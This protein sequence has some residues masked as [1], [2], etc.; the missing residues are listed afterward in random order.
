MESE[1]TEQP[2]VPQEEPAKEEQVKADTPKEEEQKKP[3]EGQQQKAKKVEY[4]FKE[5]P[6]TSVYTPEELETE[7]SKILDPVEP[8]DKI[9]PKFSYGKRHRIA[10]FYDDESDEFKDKEVKVC[11]WAR[12][13]KAAAKGAIYFVELYDGSCAGSLQVVVDQALSNFSELTTEGVGTSFQF[14]GTLIESPGKGQKYE[15][16][17]KEN[18][19][20]SMKIF[21]TCPQG[22]Y[23]LPKKKHT[24]EYLRD[25]MHLRP[26]TNLIGAV[27]RVRNSLAMATHEFFQKR[28][29]LYV[30][31]PII[32]ASDCEGAGEMFQVTTVL[33]DPSLPAKDIPTTQDGKVDYS[34]DFFKKPAFLTV[35]GQ[36]NVENFCCGMGDVYTFSP[37]FRAEVSHTKKHLAEFWMIEPEMAF[38]DL[39]DDMDCAEE[40]VKYC[41]SYVMKN[42]ADDLEYLEKFESRTLTKNLKHILDNDFGR[43]SYTEA[44]K[45]L[46]SKAKKAKFDVAPEWGVD[47]ATE[48]ERF[49]TEKI[50]KK[51]IF[52]YN[53]PKDIKAFYMRL[54]DDNKTVAAMDCLVPVIGELVG[55][56]QREERLDVLESRISECNLPSENYWWYTELRK[57]GSIPHSGFG[58]GFERLILLCTGV[59]NIRDIIPFPRWPG[60]ADF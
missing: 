41:I 30:H 2:Q 8:S 55:G 9:K 7:N 46:Q 37:T 5:L 21:G 25:I 50:Y 58:L 3:Q 59:E 33:P 47:L 42:N 11:G 23:K 24:K 32:T 12:N 16:V 56:S 38:A 1:K 44:I 20:H 19:K 57:F 4:K 18:D 28:G 39:R 13:V 60:H 52:V 49:L 15:L 43:V 40:Y 51:P 6:E 36:I 22:E 54:N 48:H 26:R 27:T 35:S 29:F 53:Y 45:Q 17:V 10:A 14:V 31:T 34:K